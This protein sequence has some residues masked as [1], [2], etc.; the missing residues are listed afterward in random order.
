MEGIVPVPLDPSRR[1][2]A[3]RRYSLVPA[4]VSGIPTIKNTIFINSENDYTV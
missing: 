1:S 2:S 4:L 3:M